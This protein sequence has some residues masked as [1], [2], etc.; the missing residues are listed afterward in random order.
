MASPAAAHSSTDLRS[1][2]Y[3]LGLVTLVV[4]LIGIGVAYAIDAASRS[5]RVAPHRWDSD[6]TLTRAIG[7]RNLT[8]PLAWF[9]N[10]EGGEENF[11]KQ[12]SLLFRLPVGV[13]GAVE[14]IDVT[15]VPRSSVR[16]S[17]R[18]LDGV[19]LHMFEDKEV[20]GPPGLVGKPLKEKEGYS[21]ETVW[22]DPLSADPFVAKCDAPTGPGDTGEC[23]RI[24]YLAQGLA[25]VYRFPVEALP[26]WK[27]FDN[28]LA[29]PL[30]QIGALDG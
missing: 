17:S 16:P 5:A 10:A 23:L 1:T 29:A 11:S 15:L 24:V 6:T 2:L 8:I 19:Y 27:D 18:L 28:Q 12:V 4:V 26:G 22:Y 30:R 13:D 9:R 25:A 14:R 21:S 20:A 3:T 7:G